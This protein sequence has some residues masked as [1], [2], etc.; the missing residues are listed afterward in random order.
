[1]SRRP[2]VGA[3]RLLPMLAAVQSTMLRTSPA[4]LCLAAEQPAGVANVNGYNVDS[5]VEFAATYLPDVNPQVAASPDEL[6]DKVR[7]PFWKDHIVE[8]GLSSV[9]YDSQGAIRAASFGRKMQIGAADQ[10]VY[11]G[12]GEMG[13]KIGKL[14]ML[15]QWQEQDGSL[16]PDQCATFGYLAV[17]V[18]YFQAPRSAGATAV[19]LLEYNIELARKQ[20]IKKIRSPSQGLFKDTVLSQQADFAIWPANDDAVSSAN[21]YL[22]DW[23]E[24]AS[25]P[26]PCHQ[27][28]YTG[29]L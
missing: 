11:V 8:D 25:R 12:Q 18:D 7:S 17:D 9:F 2:R 21:E 14:A 29:S 4:S 13:N 23:N 15:A 28:V 26:D 20:G 24:Y 27:W 16:R 5:A 3:K 1:M 6:R 19:E 10:D 22:T